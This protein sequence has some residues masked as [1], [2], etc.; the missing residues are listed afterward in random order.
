NR[1]LALPLLQGALA[2]ASRAGAAMPKIALGVEYDGTEFFGWQA[3]RGQRSVQAVLAAAVSRVADEPIV[4]HGAG[5]TDA[6]VHA[7]QQVVH[8]KT[9][10]ARTERQ[11]LLGVN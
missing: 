10:A 7:L 3:Q 9:S 5:R 4:V 6:G 11:W 8:L 2:R 1:E